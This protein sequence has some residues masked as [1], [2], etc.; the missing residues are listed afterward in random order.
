MNPISIAVLSSLSIV[1]ILACGF[2]HFRRIR[3]EKRASEKRIAHRKDIESR[4]LPAMRP[5]FCPDPE[6]LQPAG[7]KVWDAAHPKEA[8][9]RRER[10][11]QLAKDKEAQE[12]A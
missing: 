9:E 12:W 11:L 7:Q 8:A 5:Q 10:E 1:L 4:L 2:Y 6:E 3:A